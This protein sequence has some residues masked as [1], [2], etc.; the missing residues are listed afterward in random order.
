[1]KVCVCVLGAGLIRGWGEGEG[2]FQPL[3]LRAAIC[4]PIVM[5]SSSGQIRGGCQP[6]R[7]DYL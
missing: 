5:K 6:P 4:E 3:G 7:W 1:M 2:C